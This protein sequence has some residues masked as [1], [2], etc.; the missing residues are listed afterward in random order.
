MSAGR[1]WLMRGQTAVFS[2]VLLG[3]V[4]QIWTS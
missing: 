4:L 3:G 2:G 1:G